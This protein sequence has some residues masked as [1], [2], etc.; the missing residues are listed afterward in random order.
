M[1]CYYCKD[2]EQES[3]L[4]I[5][6]YVRHFDWKKL[7][8]WQTRICRIVLVMIGCVVYISIVCILMYH[9]SR[10]AESP[11]APIATTQPDRSTGTSD[12]TQVTYT[13]TSSAPTELVLGCDD[14]VQEVEVPAWNRNLNTYPVGV[15]IVDISIHYDVELSVD[16]MFI[17]LRTTEQIGDQQCYLTFDMTNPGVALFARTNEC[18]YVSEQ[19]RPFGTFDA[20]PAE[21]LKA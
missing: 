14:P 15:T 7:I 4:M 11:S 1:S 16:V 17:V 20:Q 3:G 2:P 9:Y 21:K 6:H 18:R 10:P 19:L 5:L 13:G 8:N 12:C